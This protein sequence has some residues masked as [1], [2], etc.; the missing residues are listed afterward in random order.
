MT[1]NIVRVLRMKGRKAM[2]KA[3]RKYLG[4]SGSEIR[5]GSL[6]D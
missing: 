4:R 3:M 5:A 2:R 1:L 6:Q